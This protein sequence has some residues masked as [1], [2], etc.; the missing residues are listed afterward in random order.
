[1]AAVADRSR[2]FIGAG[3]DWRQLKAKIPAAIF[4]LRKVLIQLRLRIRQRLNRKPTAAPAESSRSARSVRIPTHARRK[5]LP[6]PEVATSKFSEREKIPR[7][8][9]SVLRDSAGS[10][11]LVL[12]GR[13]PP[14]NDERFHV[15]R[16]QSD[17]RRIESLG[18]SMA[19]MPRKPLTPAAPSAGIRKDRRN[20]PPQ[21]LEKI[22][23][24]AY[25][26]NA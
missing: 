16:S 9:E 3:F 23:P 15:G 14:G 25:E 22:N 7:R 11:V 20:S 17:S 2:Q 10:A 13:R 8:G 24:Q 1:M 4:P 26:K 21:M 19:S 18:N 12:P 6:R 5:I